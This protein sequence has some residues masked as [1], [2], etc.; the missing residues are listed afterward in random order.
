MLVLRIDEVQL[1]HQLATV[2]DTYL[3]LMVM[4]STSVNTISALL[5]QMRILQMILTALITLKNHQM[6]MMIAQL[7]DIQ[8]LAYVHQVVVLAVSVV[9]S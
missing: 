6:R 9:S 8:V 2:A 1:N 3:H 7:I 4:L 5:S